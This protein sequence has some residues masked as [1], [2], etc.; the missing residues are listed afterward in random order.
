V[1]EFVNLGSRGGKIAQRSLVLRA[2]PA[3]EV[4]VRD[5]EPHPLAELPGDDNC[6]PDRRDRRG[7]AHS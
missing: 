5:V 2:L 4:R 7:K 1:L 6:K 3:F